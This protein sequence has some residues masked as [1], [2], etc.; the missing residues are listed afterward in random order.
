MIPRNEPLE[1]KLTMLACQAA[2]KFSA[3]GTTGDDRGLRAFADA[4]TLPGGLRDVDWDIEAREEIA[5][6]ANYA[7]WGVI[8]V[9]PGYLAGD[10]DATRHYERRMRTLVRCV[11]AWHELHTEAH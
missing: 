5:D 2:G 1:R 3:D 10:P 8:Q 7:V 9:Y 4:R 11:Q 6:L